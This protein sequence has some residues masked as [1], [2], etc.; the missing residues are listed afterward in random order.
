MANYKGLPR[1]GC[2]R[3]VVYISKCKFALLTIFLIPKL[4]LVSCGEL[5]ILF[6]LKL[7]PFRLRLCHCSDQ[8]NRVTLIG[9]EN[10]APSAEIMMVLE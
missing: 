3:E 10:Q 6:L 2:F 4:K 8:L 7:Y 5:D 9:V 1:K